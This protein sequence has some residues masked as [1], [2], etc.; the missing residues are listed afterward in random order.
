MS[1]A[2][3]RIVRRILDLGFATREQVDEAAAIRHKMI[4]MG[5]KAR[6]LT[7]VLYEKGYL[8]EEQLETLRREER[9]FEGKEQIAGYRLLE[10]LGEGAMGSVYKARQLSLDRDVAVKVLSPALSQNE[11]YVQRFMAEA[12][13]VARLNH[14]NIISGIDVG[15]AGGIK[16][17]VMEFADGNTLAFL[18]R[19]G[20]PLDEERAL[21]IALQIARALDH[22]H[23]NGLLHRDVKPDNVIVTRDGVA[24]LCDLGLARLDAAEEAAQ[25]PHRVGTADYMSPEQIRAKPADARSD[26]YGLGA[27]LFHAL[28][29]RVPY[30]AADRQGV[31]A[32]HLTAPVP[33]A[34]ASMPDL[35]DA[36]EAVLKRL[37][38]KD[39]AQ[40]FQS[41]AELLPAL[42]EAIKALQRARTGGGEAVSS[43][44]A[45]GARGDA[46]VRRRRR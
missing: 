8:Q 23:K 30:E 40:R 1:A 39:P 6:P 4:E 14:T 31:M 5:L 35:S 46:P 27:T 29:G 3:E 21:L 44:A 28:T 20:G 18:L 9:L 2:E 38:A 41:A 17:L 34:K 33:S 7:E 12:K 22:A 11:A 19:R 32:K 16:Y 42:D 13:A 10:L 45:P 36:T 15:D 25:D 37:L 26:L 43:G 24:K